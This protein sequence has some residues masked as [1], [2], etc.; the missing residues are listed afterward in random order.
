MG[1]LTYTLRATLQ[2]LTQSDARLY[3]GLQQEPGDSKPASNKPAALLDGDAPASWEELERLSVAA[4]WS[5]C[6]GRGIKG[7][8]NGSKPK[9]V[10]ALLSHPDGPPLRSALPVKATKGSRGGAT[11]GLNAAWR[12]RSYRC[13][14]AAARFGS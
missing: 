7:L 6:K 3:R 4:L 2:D 13:C 14:P 5:L 1:Q 12:P 10:D 9:Q 11:G 8:R